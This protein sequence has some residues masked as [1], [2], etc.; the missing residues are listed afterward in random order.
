MFDI[1][2]KNGIIIDGTGN[3]SYKSDIAIEDCK[4]VKIG[5]LNLEAKEVLDIEG[6]I[7]APGFIDTHSHS[8]LYLIHEPESLQKIMQGITIEIIG[9]DGL[10]EAPINQEHLE[11]WRKYLSGLNGDPPIKWSWEKFRDYLKVLEESKPAVNVASLVGHGNLR[12][13]A[14]GMDDKKPTVSEL[15]EMKSLLK[16]SLEDGAI[17]MSTGMIYAPCVYADTRE[18]IELCKLVAEYAGVFV[19]HMRDEGDRLLESIDEVIQ[20]AEKSGVHAHISH[21]KAGGKRNW[22]KSKQALQKLEEAKAKGIQISYDQYPYTAGSTFL[23]SLLPSWVHEGGVEKMLKRLE[24]PS[25]REKIK[26]EY[27]E[28]LESGRATGWDK[29][30]VT[31]VESPKNKNIEG[32]SLEEISKIREQFPIDA[33]IDLI[34]EETN[35]ASMANFTMSEEDVKR[36]IKNPLGMVCTDGLLLGKP[37]PR[38]YGAFPRVLSHYSREQKILRIEE[39]VRRMTSYPA[40]V[41]NL[42]KRGYILSDYIADLVV[43]DPNKVKDTSTF[44][45]PRQFPEGIKHVIV[46]GE[47]SVKNGKFTGLK[48]GKIIKN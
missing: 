30:L 11:E 29:V 18:L 33:L 15:E 35:M 48:N 42:G 14:M 3:P 8:D 27:G 2:L 31:Y 39:A 6:L 17:G 21:F 1:V 37:H 25:I 38:A 46:S 10:G 47:L 22:G 40:R 41:F 45:E 23:S 26:E 12:L 20:I 44:E 34:I 4:I 7:V 13:L 9:Q 24:E 32:K 5:K 43:F 16:E 19:I 28:K 36:I